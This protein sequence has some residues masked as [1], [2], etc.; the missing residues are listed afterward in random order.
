MA[1]LRQDVF[2]II[3]LKVGNKVFNIQWN[4]AEQTFSQIDYILKILGISWSI[5]VPA[6]E[7]KDMDLERPPI[8]FQLKTI[9]QYAGIPVDRIKPFFDISAGQKLEPVLELVSVD[10][11]IKIE[12]LI[13]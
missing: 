11:N 6:G 2:G 7:T 4:S 13:R 3:P 12:E 1:F 9:G 5:G 8:M 10:P